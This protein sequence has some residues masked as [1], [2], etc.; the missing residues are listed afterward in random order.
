MRCA[1]ASAQRHHAGF[2]LQQ[3]RHALVAD[4]EEAAE[5][6]GLQ[7]LVEAEVEDDVQRIAMLG[8]G[9]LGGVAVDVLGIGRLLR[10]RHHHAIPVALEDHAGPRVLGVLAELGAPRRIAE[11]R[12]QLLGRVGLDRI[13]GRVAVERVGVGHREVER[14]RLAGDLDVETGAATERGGAVVED[15]QARAPAPARC[16]SPC[17]CPGKTAGRT[18]PPSARAPAAS[19]R[20]RRWRSRRGRAAPWRRP[21]RRARRSA[22]W[23]TASARR[24][25]PSD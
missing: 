22:R 1:P 11:H 7:I 18:W 20:P 23:W 24:H 16:T 15:A 13:E 8:L 10:H 6:G 3:P 14:Q 4:I 12:F 9:D 17:R 5:E 19:S 25:S 2:V 21:A